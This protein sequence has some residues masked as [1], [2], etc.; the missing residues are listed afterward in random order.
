[1]VFHFVEVAVDTSE[2]FGFFSDSILNLTGNSGAFFG[3][4][5]N[6][7]D[8]R[9]YLL[10]GRIGLFRQLLD[11]PC[12]NCEASSI[13]TVSHTAKNSLDE[14]LR[15]NSYTTQSAENV[16]SS[17]S[18]VSDAVA[19]ITT[20]AQMIVDI[21]DQTNLLSLNASIEAARAGEAGRG[22]AILCAP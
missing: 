12:D 21:S 4:A 10:C 20:A 8:D 2:R 3:L 7:F 19:Q 15:A 22:F 17:I 13:T 18:S 16:I 11:F 5:R 14:L 9:L 6:F 1:M